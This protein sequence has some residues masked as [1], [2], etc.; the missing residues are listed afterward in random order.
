M[1][2]TRRQQKLS[3]K[4]LLRATLSAT[5]CLERNIRILIGKI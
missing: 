1:L 5:D 3:E 2:I 4:A